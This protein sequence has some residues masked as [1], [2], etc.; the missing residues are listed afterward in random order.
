MMASAT[1]TATSRAVPFASVVVGSEGSEP[2]SQPAAGKQ[3]D[4]DGEEHH[5]AS[6]RAVAQLAS[7][8][9]RTSSVAG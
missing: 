8:S 9:W 7:G 1:A 2:V 5:P 4:A 3:D 6:D